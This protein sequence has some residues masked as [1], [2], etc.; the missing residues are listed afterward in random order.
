MLRDGWV[1]CWSKSKQK[2]YYKHVASGHRVWDK[3]SMQAIENSHMATLLPVEE[4]PMEGPLFSPTAGNHPPPRKNTL[5]KVGMIKQETCQHSY[6][7][8]CRKLSM[9]VAVM[10]SQHSLE[11]GSDGPLVVASQPTEDTAHLSK[12]ETRDEIEPLADED[13][14]DDHN[15]GNG[16][17]EETQDY[18]GAA[19][20]LPD[21]KQHHHLSSCAPE[22]TP[23][24]GKGN[25]VGSH[26]KKMGGMTYYMNSKEQA[27]HEDGEEEDIPI[28]PRQFHLGYTK[29]KGGAKGCYATEE[30]SQASLKRGLLEQEK[31]QKRMAK[32]LK[33]MGSSDAWV[34]DTCNKRT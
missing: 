28:V 9:A 20:E 16:N 1:R 25:M 4:E 12:A 23:G 11:N 18:V 8:A 34:G 17:N 29:C 7:E 27:A 15:I 32:I 30:E 3:S 5:G 14:L 24:L 31:A 10:A 26:K 22:Y 19:I 33:Q 21:D 13:S 2:V 6:N